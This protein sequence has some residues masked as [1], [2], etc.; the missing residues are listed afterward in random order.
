[1][2][3][4]LQGAFG[5]AKAA[6]AA[7]QGKVEPAS[8]IME[9]AAVCL[10]CPRRVRTTGVSKVSQRLAELSR[11]NNADKNISDFSCG[12]CGCS[13][14]LLLSAVPANIHKDSE[15]EER[16]RKRTNCWINKLK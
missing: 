11:L 5:A 14:L 6:A 16:Q 12:I 13:L 1:M 3:L 10:S 4:T 15:L 7:I 9:R 8:V 2:K